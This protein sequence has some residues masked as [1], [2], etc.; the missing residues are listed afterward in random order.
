MGKS[1]RD[2]KTKDDVDKESKWDEMLSQI[3][4]IANPLASRKMTKKLYKVI[5]KGEWAIMQDIWHKT[6][7]WQQRQR[8][9]FC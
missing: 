1:K 3:E 4:P 8:R 7:H 9:H 2:D 6:K 5:K